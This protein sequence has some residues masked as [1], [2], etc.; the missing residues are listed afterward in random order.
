MVLIIASFA[1]ATA[2][3]GHLG[4]PLIAP[5]AVTA[6]SSQVFSRNFNGISFAAVPFAPAPVIAPFAPAPVVASPFLPPR[7]V[8]PF[9]H[10]TYPPYQPIAA[11]PY[12][13]PF[14]Y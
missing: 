1:Y 12:P 2:T 14:Y 4:A 9:A 5:A 11:Y 10:Y 8:A 3:P 7:V 6:Q 13:R